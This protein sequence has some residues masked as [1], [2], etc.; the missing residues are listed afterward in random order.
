MAD[1]SWPN[2]KKTVHCLSLCPR[3]WHLTVHNG[4]ASYLQEQSK[5]C[6]D[7]QLFISSPPYS[8]Q[9]NHSSLHEIKANPHL[10]VAHDEKDNRR[11][12]PIVWQ[13]GSAPPPTEKDIFAAQLIM[14]FPWDTPSC[15][16]SLHIQ[17]VMSKR[18]NPDQIHYQIFCTLFESFVMLPITQ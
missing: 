18:H 3:M 14:T 13:F 7:I 9:R 5:T 4:D 16:N 17:T 2:W 15:N 8:M 6:L 11:E 1:L 10:L 12:S